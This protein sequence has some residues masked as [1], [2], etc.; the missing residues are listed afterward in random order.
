[1][2]VLWIFPKERQLRDYRR[3]HCLC[4]TCGEK[5]E[6][7]HAAKCSKKPKAQLQVLSAEDMEKE[8]SEEVLTHLEQ[9]DQVTEELCSISIHVVSATE[10]VESIRLSALVKNQMFLLLVD[11]GSSATFVNSSFV[12][13]V[14]L[15]PIQCKVVP[16]D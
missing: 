8:L 5:F 4:F 3:L 13:Q 6:V 14:G 15:Q 7:G 9:E 16:A 2:L 11:S 12:Q 1:V 10:G